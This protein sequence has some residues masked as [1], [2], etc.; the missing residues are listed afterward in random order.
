VVAVVAAVQ[1]R[2]K[3]AVAV[4]VLVDTELPPYRFLPEQVIR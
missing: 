4:E 3:K 2:E 1:R